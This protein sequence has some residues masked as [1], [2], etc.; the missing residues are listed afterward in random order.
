MCA[1]MKAIGRKERVLSHTMVA[2]FCQLDTNWS[3]LDR[4]TL[5]EKMLSAVK[6]VGHLILF[7]LDI[8]D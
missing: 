4:G 8:L 3:Y 7:P 2:S 6:C 5:V 1:G